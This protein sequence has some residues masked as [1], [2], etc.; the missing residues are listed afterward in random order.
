M[1]LHKT[2]AAI[3]AAVALTAVAGGSVLA[4]DEA[5]DAIHPRRSDLHQLVEGLGVTLTRLQDE[6]SLMDV[7]ARVRGTSPHSLDT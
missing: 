1:N 6:I 4:Q 5:G 7:T 2:A 3:L